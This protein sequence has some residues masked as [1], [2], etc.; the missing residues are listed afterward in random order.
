MVRDVPVQMLDE[1]PEFIKKQ[2]RDMINTVGIIISKR[3]P[4][5]LS[6]IPPLKH[7]DSPDNR[8]FTIPQ[9]LKIQESIILTMHSP[10]QQQTVSLVVY[11]FK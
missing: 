3:F 5:Y 1:L 6:I 11:Y 8:H 7:T 2:A 10:V 9:T 4:I